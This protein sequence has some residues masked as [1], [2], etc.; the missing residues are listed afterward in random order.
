[1]RNWRTL[2][3]VCELVKKWLTRNEEKVKAVKERL[4]VKLK[5]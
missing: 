5:E 3:I 1:M 2:L 4:L